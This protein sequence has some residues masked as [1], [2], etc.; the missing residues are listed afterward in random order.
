MRTLSVA[1]RITRVSLAALPE[2]RAIRRLGRTAIAAEIR[3]L[4]RTLGISGVS[5]TCRR[6]G[7]VHIRIPVLDCGHRDVMVPLHHHRATCRVCAQGHAAARRIRYILETVFD[8][9]D[10]SDIQSDY[11][12]FVYLIHQSRDHAKTHEVAA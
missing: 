12:N 10:R 6:G 8:I 4:F 3:A 2:P 5:V 11:F 9:E 7:H 1:A